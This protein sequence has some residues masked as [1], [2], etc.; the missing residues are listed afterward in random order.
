VLKNKIYNF[1][2]MYTTLCTS[3]LFLLN[4]STKQAKI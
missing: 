2:E 1:D 4:K 3:I